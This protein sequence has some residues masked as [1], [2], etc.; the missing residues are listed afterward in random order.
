MPVHCRGA[1]LC[2][3]P[4]SL[5][6]SDASADGVEVISL[7]PHSRS[8]ARLRRNATMSI[9][10]KRSNHSFRSTLVA[11]HFG[12]FRLIL[13]NS[14]GAYTNGS[15]YQKGT[16]IR[17]RNERIKMKR[18]SLRLKETDSGALAGRI[19]HVKVSCRWAGP[20]RDGRGAA[21]ALRSRPSLY[22]ARIVEI[23]AFGVDF[24]AVSESSG[25]PIF[26]CPI[27]F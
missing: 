21:C 25:G 24:R 19:R 27:P 10:S 23:G 4:L 3:Q 26:R 6:Y 7:V 20:R 13:I 8:H 15:S 22:D 1:R 12:S 5:F 18:Y 9:T 17:V 16:F 14:Y 11:R 2:V